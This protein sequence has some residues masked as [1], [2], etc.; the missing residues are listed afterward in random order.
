MNKV[1]SLKQ[2]AT[3]P[4]PS[5]RDLGKNICNSIEERNYNAASKDLVD[6]SDRL[7]EIARRINGQ[8]AGSGHDD[9]A[10]RKAIEDLQDDVEF[11]HPHIRLLDRP[12]LQDI[13]NSQTNFV[14]IL[15]ASGFMMG[16]IS[17]L[18]GGVT[19]VGARGVRLNEDHQCWVA[20]ADI[21]GDGVRAGT[22]S[23]GAMLFLATFLGSFHHSHTA[24]KELG[25]G[26]IG[27]HVSL[28]LAFIGPLA[29]GELS[30]VDGILGSM[31]LDVQN[32]AL[33][34]QLMEKETL[35]ARWQVGAVMAAQLLGLVT[36]GILVH[37]FSQ[38]NLAVD[39]CRCFSVFWWSWFKY[40]NL[41]SKMHSELP[42]TVSQLYLEYGGFGWLSMAAAER[43]IATQSIRLTSPVYSIGQITP[44]VIAGLT[45]LRVVWVTSMELYKQNR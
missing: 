38:D 41:G 44:I 12:F 20:D 32:S 16:A 31:V 34:M 10:S 37:S 18:L 26:L 2:T 4:F 13:S 25:S 14:R 40:A 7:S 30:P 17:I 1:C 43:T 39:G 15:Q 24:V 23:Q 35:A 27:M 21:I 5:I 28:A 8:I 45:I 9:I 3:A 29:T 22:W 11:L 33:S 36:I 6:M 19:F 42:T